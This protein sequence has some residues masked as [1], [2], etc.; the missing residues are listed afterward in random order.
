VAAIVRTP[1]LFKPGT[2]YS[3]QSMGI[4]LAAEMV[5]RVA[6]MPLP[7]FLKANVF[8]PLG[9]T[10][11][12]LGLGEF[13]LADVM[14]NQTEHA[15]PES[16]AGAANAAEWNWNSA[17]WRNL[18]APWGGGHG[19][20][21]DIAKF[22]RSFMHPQ[23]KALKPETARLMI[24]NQTQG[25]D[26]ARGIGFDLRHET[27]GKGCSAHTFGHSG[28]TGN[29]AWADPDKDLTCVILTSL[30]SGVSGPLILHPVS[31]VVSA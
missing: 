11:T 27:F 9:M 14:L 6:H 29:L 17:Y 1:L 5:Q 15:A 30:P 8:T 20:A 13:K 26:A 3:Y 25:L 4:M 22:L 16:G 2:Q 23:G 31:D 18:G 12:E 21:G 28:S 10:R 7:E 19:T 24:Q